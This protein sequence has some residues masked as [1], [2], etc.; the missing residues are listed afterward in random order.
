MTK[1]PGEIHIGTSGYQYDH[2]RGAFYPKDIPKKAWFHY[3][4]ERFQTVEINNTFYNLPKPETF[5]DWAHNAPEG[6]RYALKFSGYGTHQKK[7][8]DP[9][10]PIGRFLSHATRLGDHLGP[11]LVQLPPNW[12]PDFE[13]LDRFLT[14][15]AGKAEWV[16]E[17]REREWLCDEL[18]EILRNHRAALCIHDLIADHPEVLTTSWTYRR[19][20]GDHYRGSYSSQKLTAV[21]QRIAELRQEGFAVYAY[22]N[23]DEAGYAAQNALQL[24]E[25]VAN[26][27]EKG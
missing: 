20:H 8:K 21:A 10:E 27:V 24:V 23:N 9:E 16:V 13:R 2:W 15:A 26:A 22:F 18:Y 11:I 19:F 7:L 17:V 1:N 3:Y 12:H 6:F 4:A 14:V 25:Y 5:E